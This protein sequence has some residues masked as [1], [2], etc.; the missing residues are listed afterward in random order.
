MQTRQSVLLAAVQHTSTMVL[1]GGRED[2]AGMPGSADRCPASYSGFEVARGSLPGVVGRPGKGAMVT[3]ASTVD[4]GPLVLAA[5]DD[6]CSSAFEARL[7]RWPVEHWPHDLVRRFAAHY[8]RLIALPRRSRRSMERRSKC[9]LAVIAL[10][11]ALG[12]GPAWAATIGVAPGTPPAIVAD[13]KCSLSEAIVNANRDRRTYL[14]CVAGAGADTI[15]LPTKSVQ[16]LRATENLPSVTSRIVVEGRQST[17]QRN[18]WRDSDL[19]LVRVAAS[20]DLTL[21]NTTVSGATASGAVGGSP[22]VRN[23][24]GVV[25]LN[26]SRI[27]N[28]GH[29]LANA[30]GVASLENSTVS[31]NASEYGGGGLSNA[32]GGTLTLLNSRVTGN[33]GWLDTPGIFNGEGSSLTVIDSIVSDNVVTYETAGGGIENRGTLVLVGSTVSGNVADIGGGIFNAF[34]T[35]TATLIDSTVSGNRASSGYSYGGGGIATAGVMTLHNCTVSGNSAPLGAG[36]YVWNEGAVTLTHTT[37]TGNVAR[38]YSGSSGGGVFVQQGTLTLR[39]SIVS[40]NVATA[41]PEAREIRVTDYYASN[42]VRADDYNVFGHDGDAGTHGFTPGSTDIVPNA[43]LGGLLLPLADDGGGTPT[44]ALAIGSPALDASPGDGACPATDQR[45]N[46]R[47]RGPACDTGAFEGVAVV[48]NGAVTTMVGTV[49]DDR[50]TGTA[51]PDV[52]SGLG[53]NDTIFGLEGNDVICGGFGADRLE[54]GPGRDLLFGEPGDDRLMGQGGNDALNGGAGRDQCDGGGG[55][56]DTAAACEAV[57]HV[58]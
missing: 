32:G 1:R 40:G 52:I 15:V 41:A 13:G 22:G 16:R 35:A 26:D 38:S 5:F 39:R 20:G 2:T 49:A 4:P 57:T 9:T 6:A 25:R 33:Q 30:G 8:R 18:A 51:G 48:C 34:D 27:V 19:P 50:L 21:R 47:P 42:V 56:G 28:T 43:P 55:T 37:V 12:Q 31:G 11:M 23:D 44:H 45:G 3:S 53:G 36:I 14:D 10:S 29:G 17:I 24:G 58:P 7:Q 54:G 46:P